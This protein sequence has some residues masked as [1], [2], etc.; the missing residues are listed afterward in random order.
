MSRFTYKGVD[1]SPFLKILEIKKSIGNER[2]V[3]TNDTPKIGVNVQGVK[4]GAKTIK[5]RVSLA[6]RELTPTFVDTIEY[7][8]ASND[9]LNKLREKAASLLHAESEFR[10]ELPDEPDRFY[11]A[12]PRGDIEL[13]GISDW[14]DETTIEFLVPDG[15]AHST[16]YKRFDAPRQEGNK[17]I[18]DLE[19]NGTVDAYPI[20]TVKHASENGYIGLVNVSGAME[21]GSR[22]E[23]DKEE[24]KKSETLFD[25]VPSTGLAKGQKNVAILNDQ[26]QNLG[27]TLSVAE[28][29]GRP[30]ISLTNRGSGPRQANAGSVTWDI[31][32]D[33]SGESGSLNDYIWWRQVF[34]ALAVNQLGFIKIM[35]S[36][37]ND[38]FLYGVETIKR[39]N[40]LSTE[41]NLLA[42]NGQGGF[43]LIKQWIFDATERDEHNPFNAS[44]GASD[45]EETTWFKPI[46]GE[47]ISNS[48]SPKSKAGNRIKSMLRLGHLATSLFYRIC[49]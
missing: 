2:T 33:S 12:I 28:A 43:K 11:M 20:V 5:V 13:E 22:E 26:G 15:V 46:G 25:Y 21:L 16:A 39:A 30:H 23:A 48:T 19:N 9:N 37:T 34:I 35:V 31:P 32:I 1:L 10:L 42:S 38:Q 36:D 44:R 47:V 14:Y 7:P 6:S 45:L 29:F 17:A 24:Y 4:F 41:Y 8:I 49:I 3:E 18:F 40:G 27:G